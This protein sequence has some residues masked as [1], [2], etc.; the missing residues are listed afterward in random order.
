MEADVDAVEPVH[1]RRRITGD[2]GDVHGDRLVV[3]ETAVECADPDDI[4]VVMIRI[5]RRLEIGPEG[6]IEGQY[7]DRRID[8]E[9]VTIASADDRIREVSFSF[10]ETVAVSPPPFEVITGGS[11]TSMTLT[12]RV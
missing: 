1:S 11:G 10:I 8:Q 7:A 9:F 3:R 12:V 2:V 5:A 4:A 6:R